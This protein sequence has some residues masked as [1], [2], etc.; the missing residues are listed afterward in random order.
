M[1][2]AAPVAV[3]AVAIL[4]GMLIAPQPAL[5]AQATQIA[6][7]GGHTCAL[8]SVGGVKCWGYNNYGQLGDNTTT[9]RHTPVDVTGLQSGV[10]QLTTNYGHTCALTAA[11]A[12][13]CWGYNHNGQLGDDTTTNRH[14]PVDVTGLQSGVTQIAA[15]YSHT[16]A[17][18]AAGGVKCWGWNSW[19]Q[20]GDNSTT[21]RH[22]PVDVT[23][24]ASGVTQIAAGGGHT[25]ALTDAGGVNCWGANFFGQLGDD[26]I[27]DRHTPVDAIGLASGVTQITAGGGHT[28]ALTS[29]GGVKCWGD[30]VRGVVG[31]GTTTERHTPA[32]VTGLASGVTQIAS[33]YDHTCA[34]TAIGGVKCWGWNSWGQLGDNSTTDRHTPVDV[35]GLASGVS[36]IAAGGS[37]T[38]ALTAAGGVKCWGANLWG[39]LGDNSTIWHRYPVFVQG[40]GGIATRVTLRSSTSRTATGTTVTYTAKIKPRPGGGRVRFTD[41]GMTIRGCGAVHVVQGIARCSKHYNKPGTHR[42]VAHYL[43]TPVHKASNSP[44]LVQVIR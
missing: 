6:S 35:T 8:T 34:L 16:C 15:G 29:A 14:T 40:F 32:D 11:G 25:C 22:T 10:T 39:Q 43:G 7:G 9:D 19:G 2:R 30:N 41:R 27:T 38:C 5:A 12:V 31:D 26:T 18:T 13:K 28:C 42:I 36:Q 24:L 1:S 33:D 23:G 4:A 3:I 17:L 37:H 20:L 21:D 44:R